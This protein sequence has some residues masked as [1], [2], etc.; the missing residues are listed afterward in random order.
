MSLRV[1]CGL[2][3]WHLTVS[4]RT[5]CMQRLS[6]TPSRMSFV[7]QEGVRDLDKQNEHYIKDEK[8]RPGVLNSLLFMGN[9]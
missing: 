9:V 7:F 1:F 5:S 4:L 8:H 6:L 2:K 3:I